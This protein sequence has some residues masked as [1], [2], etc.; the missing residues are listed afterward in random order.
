MAFLR[1][2]K[3]DEDPQPRQSDAANQVPGVTRPDQWRPKSVSQAL[4]ALKE[5]T[6]RRDSWV[7]DGVAAPPPGQRHARSSG[8]IEVPPELRAPAPVPPAPPPSV[9]APPPSVPTAA[10]AEAGLDRDELHDRIAAL[11][12][13]IAT[14]KTE[15]TGEQDATIRALQMRQAAL[16]EELQKADRAYVKP[17]PPAAT[18]LRVALLILVFAVIAGSPLFMSRRTVC[19]NARGTHTHWAIVKPFDDSGPARCDNQL[20][21]SVL[22]D[23]VG[24]Q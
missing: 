3:K 14:A 1:R 17:A 10:A 6:G 13:Q 19:H 12:Q 22:L 8:S 24:L 11:E 2:R 7:P 16:E 21:G 5:P 18:A 20:G 4:P 15:R 9:P 23:S